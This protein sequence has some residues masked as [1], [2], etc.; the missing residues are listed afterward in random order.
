MIET[1]HSDEAIAK[2]V[3]ETLGMDL[4]AQCVPGVAAN[5]R[6]LQSHIAIMRKSPEPGR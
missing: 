4:P 5:V 1:A 6:L 3:G 2:A